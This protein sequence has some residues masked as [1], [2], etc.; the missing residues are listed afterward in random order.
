MTQVWS[1]RPYLAAGALVLVLGLGGFVL[2]A[3]LCQISG[4]VVVQ[5]R[6]AFEMRRQIVQHP[7]GGVISQIHVR[8][9]DHVKAGDALITLDDTELRTQRK[10]LIQALSKTTARIVQLTSRIADDE[11]LRFPPELTQ[12]GSADPGV[13]RI[14]DAER[15][16][17]TAFNDTR[18]MAER[19]FT[20]RK[21]QIEAQ[22]AGYTRQRAAQTR[23]RAF[24]AQELAVQSALL[25]QGLSQTPRVLALQRQDAEFD[26]R[27]GQLTA[28]IAEARSRMASDQLEMLGQQTAQRAAAQEELRELL[29][30]ETDL[31]ERLALIETRIGRRVLRAPITG[32]IIDL[33]LHTLGGVMPAGRDVLSIVPAGSPLTFTAQIDPREIDRVTVGQPA[34][35]Q[36]PSFNRRTTPSFPATVRNLSADVMRD[37]QTQRPYFLAQ[38]APS[39]PGLPAPVAQGLH[40]GT[41]FEG[42]IGT[43]A[44]SVASYLMKP[45]GDY[46]SYALRED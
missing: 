39:E 18:A 42:F 38:L 6:V 1:A 8:D 28:Q 36:F 14:L 40:P 35:L 24:I 25:D 5:G 4:A 44:R 11:T 32:E 43:G 2:W 27:I 10:L 22:I 12:A 23:Q 7:D 13:A 33:H 34:T 26:G 46:L 3:A 37:P 16:A 45:L 30:A 15:A 41:P 29:P 21:T 17:F 19:Q 31:R 9:G 20:Q